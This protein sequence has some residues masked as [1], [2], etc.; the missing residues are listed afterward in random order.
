MDHLPVPIN[1]NYFM[2]KAFNIIT[3]LF[4]DACINSIL[5]NYYP[6]STASMPFHADDEAAIVANS[7]IFTLSIGDKRDIVFRDMDRHLEVCRVTL[8]NTVLLIFSKN[9]QLSFQHAIP[10][11]TG[12]EL[13]TGR[14]SLTLRHIV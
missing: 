7:F 6:S 8:D 10:P 13:S 9:S 1:S 5:V 11:S 4:P 3:R 12:L 14:I 2:N